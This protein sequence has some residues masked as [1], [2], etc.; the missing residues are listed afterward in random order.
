MKIRRKAC[1]IFCFLIQVFYTSNLF[2]KEIPHP[3]Y[4]EFLKKFPDGYPKFIGTGK[5]LSGSGKVLGFNTKF[6]FSEILS[7]FSEIFDFNDIFS[8]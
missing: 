3:T 7:F 4:L 8:F 5:N 2:S 6:S 1:I